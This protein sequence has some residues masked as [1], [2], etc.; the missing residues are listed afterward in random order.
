MS[1]G[2][3]GTVECPECGEAFDPTAEGGRCTNPDCGEWAYDGG[4]DGEGA[5]DAGSAESSPDEAELTC[6]GCGEAVEAGDNF[7]SNCGADVSLVGSG[8]LTDCPNC[9]DPVEPEDNYCSTCGEHLEPYR[10]GA[11]TGTRTAPETERSTGADER[12]TGGSAGADERTTDPDEAGATGDGDA[13]E[14]AGEP[15]TLVVRNREMRVYDGD[16]L[17]RAI[18]S[19]VMDTGG[20]EE[21]AVRIHRE[22]VRFVRE[23]GQFYLEA[24]G[25]NPTEVN[26]EPV[27]QGERVPVEPD[28]RI[29]LSNVAR[30]RVVES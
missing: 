11:R 6:P 29:E 27:E 8:P 16:T 17:G 22:H 12:T 26:A 20:D 15:L 30:L 19:I 25:Q 18:R 5:G 13:D 23:D 2:T 24:L 28:D 14:R 3:S 4:P 7:C 10:Q 9:E 1:K 21:D